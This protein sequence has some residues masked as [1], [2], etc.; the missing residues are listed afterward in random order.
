MVETKAK[1][2][3]KIF[4]NGEVIEDKDLISYYKLRLLEIKNKQNLLGQ[5]TAEGK[6]VF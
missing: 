2:T 1:E 5:F 3:F 4:E 6:Y